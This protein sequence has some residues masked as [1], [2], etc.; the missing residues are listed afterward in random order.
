MGQKVKQ[1]QM[2]KQKKKKKTAV[3]ALFKTTMTDF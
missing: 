1:K 2:E 3:I